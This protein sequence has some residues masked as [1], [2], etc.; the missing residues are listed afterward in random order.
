MKISLDSDDDFYAP[1]SD[2]P[3]NMADDRSV[4]WLNSLTCV[5]SSRSSDEDTRTVSLALKILGHLASFYRTQATGADSSNGAVTN[6]Y[7]TDRHRTDSSTDKGGF[8]GLSVD[9]QVL[10]SAFESCCTKY[11]KLMDQDHDDGGHAP[12][13][14]L[15]GR[16]SMGRGLGGGADAD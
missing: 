1:I 9:I 8:E 13:K 16:M 15:C 12:D 10:T 6:S 4:P 7:V 2:A 14:G 11:L 3:H 5:Y